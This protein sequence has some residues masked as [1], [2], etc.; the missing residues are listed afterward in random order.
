M[1]S[2]IIYDICV[3]PPACLSDPFLGTHEYVTVNGVKFH[4]VSNGDPDKPLLLFVH[5]FFEVDISIVLICL[6]P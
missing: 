4:C 5:G 6:I 3:V 1:Q 2:I